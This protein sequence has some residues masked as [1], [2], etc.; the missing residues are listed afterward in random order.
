MFAGG[1]A[2]ELEKRELE[3]RKIQAKLQKKTLESLALPDL[4]LASEY[5]TAE[6]MVQFKK[7][8]KKV[9]IAKPQSFTTMQFMFFLQIRKIRKKVL[10]ASDLMSIAPS[11]SGS[12][13]LGKR[14]R[15]EQPEKSGFKP[16]DEQSNVEQELQPEDMDLDSDSEDR[17]RGILDVDDLPRKYQTFLSA[18]QHKIYFLAPPEDL[19]DIKLEPDEGEL[20]LQL[21]L[22]KARKL[23]Q[24]RDFKPTKHIESVSI[25]SYFYLNEEH[26]I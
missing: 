17:R 12:S 7:P 25:T 15:D 16:V 22:N 2:R 6:E 21:A 1:E 8:K 26:I 19:S 3:K 11:T 13:D 18:T 5:Y 23:K 9:S 20:E 4:Q 10:K 14:R 24:L